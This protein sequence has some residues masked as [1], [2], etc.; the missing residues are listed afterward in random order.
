[1]LF[2]KNFLN[3]S[4]KEIKTLADFDAKKEYTANDLITFPKDLLIYKS[5]F[6]NFN[7]K[8]YDFDDLSLKKWLKRYLKII[9]KKDTVERD[10]IRFIK[11][12]NL[13]FIVGSI[14][15]N[16]SVGHHDAYLFSEVPLFNNYICDYLL[17]GTSSL[18]YEFVF[19]EFE[20]LHKNITLKNGDIGDSIRRGLKQVNDWRVWN[21]AN[22]I[23][24]RTYFEKHLSPSYDSL[25]KEFINYDSTR[26]HY[27]VVAGKRQNYKEYTR[28]IQ[29]KSR[30]SES[31]YLFHYDNLYDWS[32]QIISNKNYVNY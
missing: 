10:V 21:D 4:K 14:L 1:M 23:S 29:R 11:E 8:A 2:K 28:L 18:G 27:V 25:P 30:K 6:P 19:V 3:L 22:F 24:L 7:L 31:I 17:I 12:N 20:S 5:V 26:F 32:K 15:V 9:S 13:Y 16:F